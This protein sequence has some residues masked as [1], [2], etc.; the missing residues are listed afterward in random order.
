MRPPIVH[1]DDVIS[2]NRHMLDPEGYAGFVVNPR[3]WTCVFEGPCDICRNT[4]HQVQPLDIG[5]LRMRP[6]W[7]VRRAAPR[8]WTI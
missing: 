7:C 4:T 3:V 5:F 8:M 2:L 1:G 6:D